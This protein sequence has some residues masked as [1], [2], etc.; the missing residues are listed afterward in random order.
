MLGFL[1][2]SPTITNDEVRF[3]LRMMIWEGVTSEALAT[4]QIMGYLA[5]YALALGANN[6]QVG[7]VSA[8][9]FMSLVVQLPAI[10]LIERFR[11]RKA[12]G[13]PGVDSCPIADYPRC[14]GAL[15]C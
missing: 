6:L 9:P 14:S 13:L 5:A 15:L 2:P 3:S 7:I 10:L 8:V 11:V 4:I 12:I 1:R